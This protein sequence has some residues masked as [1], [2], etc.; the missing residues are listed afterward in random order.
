MFKPLSSAYSSELTNHLQ[1]NQGL[2][3][4]NKG[5]LFRLFWPAWSSSFTSENVLKAF[6]ATGVVP[7]NADAVLKRFKNTTLD[8][9]KDPRL[10]PRGNNSSWI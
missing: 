3:P 10:E 4:V 7:P 1:R 8:E 5:H 2:V 6:E 9:D